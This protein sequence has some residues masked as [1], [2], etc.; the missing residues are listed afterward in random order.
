VSSESQRAKTEI[1]VDG[2]GHVKVHC[3]VVVASDGMVGLILCQLSNENMAN[4][5]NAVNI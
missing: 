1:T 5:S 3:E 2:S 4:A